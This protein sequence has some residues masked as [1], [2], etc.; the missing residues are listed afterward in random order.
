MR[1]EL[2]D[3]QNHR[4]TRVVFSSESIINCTLRPTASYSTYSLK[5][6]HYAYRTIPA[7]NDRYVGWK[8]GN[9]ELSTTRSI[10][11]SHCVGYSN[12]R[13]IG[14]DKEDLGQRGRALTLWYVT[15]APHVNG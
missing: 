7:P 14:T 12:N 8:N 2:I 9:D 11:R 13:G 15:L 3:C 5:D 1:P 10:T 4:I 6:A